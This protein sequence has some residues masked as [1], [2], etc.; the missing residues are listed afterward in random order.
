MKINKLAIV[1]LAAA[2]IVSLNSCIFS[3]NTKK[4]KEM[5]KVEASGKYIKLDTLVNDFDTIDAYDS[6]DINYYQKDTVP[7]VVILAS[8]NIMPHIKVNSEN[9]RLTLALKDRLFNT[10]QVYIKVYSHS[11]KNVMMV[12]SGSFTSDSLKSDN[13]SYSCSGSGDMMLKNLSCNSFSGA[14]GGSGDI[15]LRSIDCKDFTTSVAGSGDIEA[16]GVKCDVINASVAGSGDISLS[17]SAT[18]ADLSVAGSGNIDAKHLVCNN[19]RYSTKGSG[20]IEK[21]R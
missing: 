5:S 7:C 15:K 4:L 16:S 14:V 11:L 13:F 1:M 18:K 10:G 6:F 8:D 19:I 3:V 21:P 12:G 17:G 9:G 2:S 20:D